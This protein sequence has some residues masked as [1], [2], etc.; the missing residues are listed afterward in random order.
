MG[1]WLI[2][3]KKA[4]PLSSL[5]DKRAITSSQGVKGHR[6]FNNSAVHGILQSLVA[7][8]NIAN[9]NINIDVGTVLN[10]FKFLWNGLDKN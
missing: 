9:V 3:V 1:G 4:I 2:S 6:I 10:T 8:V 7:S 5:W